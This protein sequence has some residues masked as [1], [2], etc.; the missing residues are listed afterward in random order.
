MKHI[1]IKI[2]NKIQIVMNIKLVHTNTKSYNNN[3][4]RPNIIQ[5]KNQVH[6]HKS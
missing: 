3:I 1:D 6:K 4:K 2:H 5:A